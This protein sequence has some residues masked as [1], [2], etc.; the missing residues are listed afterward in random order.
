[1][2]RRKGADRL[3][4]V[5]VAVDDLPHAIL[6]AVKVGDPQGQRRDEAAVDGEDGVF[7]AGGVGQVPAGAGGHQ[8]ER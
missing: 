6:A 8:L 1:M 3:G 7:V 2:R 4:G 5:G